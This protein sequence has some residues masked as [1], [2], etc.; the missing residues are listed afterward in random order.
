MNVLDRVV[1]YFAPERGLARVRARSAIRIYEG[2]TAGRRASSWRAL[3]TSS[4]AELQSAIRP[5]RDRSR[6]LARNTPHAARLLDVMVAHLVGN[7][8]IPISSTGKDK[9]DAQVQDLWEDWDNQADVTGRLS[10]RAM[11]GLAVRSMIESG[12]I[13]ARLVDRPLEEKPGMT[14][15]IVPFQVQLLEADFIDQ[16]R[17]GI[18]GDIATPE[19]VV[20]SRLGVALGDYD[21]VVGLWLWPYHPGELTTMNL[22][23]MTS[24]LIPYSD[25]MHVFKMQRPGQVR[26]VPWFAPILTTARDLSD[27][28]DAANVK[29]RVE[30]CFAAFIT[31]D[32]AN[33][34]ILDEAN[35]GYAQPYDASNPDAMVSMLEPGMMK[36]LRAGQDIKFANPTSTSQIEPVLLYNLMGMA[37]GVGCTYDQI[38]GDLRQANYSSLRAGKIEFWR[39]ITQQ[40]ELTIIPQLCQPVW[41]RFIARAILANYLPARKGGY[42]C[43][44]VTP[45]HEAIDPKK[46]L[47]AERNEV[48]AGRISPQQFIA[49]KGNNWRTI[50]KDIKAWNE[51]QDANGLVADIDPRKTDQRGRPPPAAPAAGAPVAADPNAPDPAQAHAAHM[52]ALDTQDAQDDADDAQDAADEKDS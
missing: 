27:F 33:A 39:L 52:A 10:F 12:E 21:K 47:D 50:A 13:V 37:A 35:S 19:S 48:R 24:E 2:A 18:Y 34:P 51:L 6:D 38:A 28:I 41:D 42:P 29:A 26:G 4:N 3:G 23:P 17:D 11:Q 46:D 20:R 36:E 9:I 31:N 14:K 5:L 25:L 15:R 40:Q 7:G 8:L 1:S 45:A 32:D 30:A 49:S 43:E 22:K 44:W 16:Y